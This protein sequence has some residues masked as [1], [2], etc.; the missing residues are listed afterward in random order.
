MVV[1]LLCVLCVCGV[2]VVGGVV[3]WCGVGASSAYAGV[4][5]CVCVVRRWSVVA[6]PR[7][8]RLGPAVGVCVG[9]VGL[10]SL[11]AEAF[12]CGAPPLLAGVRRRLW[13]VVP[14]HP[15]RGPWAWFP[16]T[17][18]LGPPAVV[19]GACLPLLALGPGVPFS[20]GL[21]CVCVLCGASCWCWWCAGFVCG[22]V[23]VCVC[24][25]VCLP[26]VVCGVCHTWFGSRLSNW[27]WWSMPE[28]RKGKQVL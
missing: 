23:A 8:S 9:V 17:P 12:S 13:W 4:R 27:T 22:V 11:L 19:V 15:G 28:S 2:P 25:F 6:C 21:M 24:V 14:R 18:G 16:A 5:G 20:L 3:W 10:S 26:C 7:L 1:V